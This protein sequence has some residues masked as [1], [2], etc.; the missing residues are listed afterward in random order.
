MSK[1]PKPK[2][3]TDFESP[4]Q[5]LPGTRD[6]L[7]TLCRLMEHQ[8]GQVGPVTQPHALQRAIEEAI[9]RREGKR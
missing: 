5:S 1:K 7:K 4:L 3:R 8:P 2:P 6:K 9:T